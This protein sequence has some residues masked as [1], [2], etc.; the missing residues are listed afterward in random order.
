[1]PV[2][3]S[4]TSAPPPTHFAVPSRR[5]RT[6]FPLRVVSVVWAMIPFATFGMGAPFTFA[7]AAVRLHSKLVGLCA[8]GYGVAAVATLYLAGNN[9][10]NSWQAN[11]G[12][13]LGFGV[14]AVATIQSFAIR[15]SV[16]EGG[17]V[18]EDPAV[19]HALE[20]LRLR[21]NARRIVA[22]NPT[23]AHE[24]QIGRPDWHRRFD[25]GGL[26]DVN[27]VPIDYLIDLPGFDRSTA[28]QLADVRD[29]IG[30]FVS[31]DDLSVT[32]GL[33]PHSLD[34]IAGRLVFIR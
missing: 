21:E 2:P 29:G 17:R 30:G 32:L 26:I 16:F 15:R 12:V 27:H 25:D 9:N 22:E 10:E 8:A 11:V 13:A 18:D 14:T 24:L 31:V 5:R 7:Y 3:E 23:L 33:H 1:M 19:A 34:K 28:Q 20:Q 6:P 4:V